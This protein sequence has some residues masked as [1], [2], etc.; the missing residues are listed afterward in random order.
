MNSGVFFDLDDTLFPHRDDTLQRIMRVC[1]SLRLGSEAVDRWQSMWI[2]HGS[3]NRGLIDTLITEGS[4]PDVKNEL[5][6]SYRSVQP[7]LTMDADLRRTISELRQEHCVIVLTNGNPIIQKSKIDALS[8][9]DLADE[10]LIAEGEFLKPSPYWI[11]FV[12][13][14]HSL[15]REKS[16]FFGD[17]DETDGGAARNAAITFWLTSSRDIGK[18][19]FNWKI[20]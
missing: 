7:N 5:L 9:W 11:N 12:I 18:D 13:E 20:S 17:N 1:E 10:L 19:I 8:L 16:V 2:E 4:L 14:R 15:A 6:D 3:K